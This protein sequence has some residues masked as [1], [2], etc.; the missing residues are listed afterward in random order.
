MKRLLVLSLLGTSFFVGYKPIKAD[1][2]YFLNYTATSY[3]DPTYE[4][5][6]STVTGDSN[7]TSLITTFNRSSN[8]NVHLRNAWIDHSLNKIFMQEV[9]SSLSNDTGRVWTYSIDDDNWTVGT[10]S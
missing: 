6:K 9:S 4:I 3:A 8:N 10:I 2:N 7:Q 5:L 1:Q